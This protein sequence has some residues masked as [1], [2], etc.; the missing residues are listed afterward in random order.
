[1]KNNK[2]FINLLLAFGITSIV[3]G[4]DSDDES[5][6]SVDFASIASTVY[7]Q[8]GTNT[9][10]LP[11]RNS[12]DV[13]SLDVVFG[14]TAQEGE[15]FELIGITD[16]GV[17][18]SIIDDSKFE[19][20]ETVRVELSGSGLNGNSIHTITIVNNC[21]DTDDLEAGFFVGAFTMR[22]IYAPDDIYGPYTLEW[23]QD[24]VNPNKYWTDHFW[25]TPNLRAYIV[26]DPA[27]KTVSFPQQIPVAISPLR[28]ITSEPAAVTDNC[29]F[30]ITTHYRGSTWEYE[31]IKHQFPTD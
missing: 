15:D 16:E 4:C 29:K 18:I 26:F 31:F 24:E 27:T 3:V 21:E 28:I 5:G 22:E 1:M 14:G 8:A 20:N 6:I 19:D 23:V 13:A 7:E 12:G 25:D 10:T 30:V 17:Q 11:L 2:L 9:V